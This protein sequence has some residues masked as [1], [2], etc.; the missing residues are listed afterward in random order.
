VERFYILK[1]TKTITMRNA[2][3]LST[4]DADA[5]GAK[6]NTKHLESL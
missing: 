4:L 5:S 2:A 3:T 1:L 6:A